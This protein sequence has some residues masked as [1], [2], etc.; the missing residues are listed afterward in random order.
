MARSYYGAREVGAGAADFSLVRRTTL[1]VLTSPVREAAVLDRWAPLEVAKFE[2]ALCLVGKNFPQ[3][4]AVVGSKTTADCIEFFY[5]W[6]QSSYNQPC[7]PPCPHPN[8][9]I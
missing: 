1:G 7:L 3:V 4:A 5:L 9:N 8:P 6:K 2:S